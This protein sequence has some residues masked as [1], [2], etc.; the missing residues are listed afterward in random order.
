MR[1]IVR[2]RSEQPDFSPGVVV[3]AIALVIVIQLGWLVWWSLLL[4]LMIPPTVNWLLVGRTTKDEI[5]IE[6]DV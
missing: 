4:I 6:K 2:V 5:T 1:R 3:A